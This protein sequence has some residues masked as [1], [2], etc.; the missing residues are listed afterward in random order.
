MVRTIVDEGVRIIVIDSLNGYLHA[1]PNEAAL[2]IQFHEL[3]TFLGRSGVTTLLVVTQPGLIGQDVV[4]PVNA[5]Y[6]VDSVIM[7]RYFE[8]SGR[9][10][11]AISVLK[12]RNGPHQRDIREL[13]LGEAGERLHVGEAL[14]DLEGVMRGTPVLSEP[15]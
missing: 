8:H 7:L 15:E 11:K 9:I 14:T 3:F 2:L 1:M 4:T 13:H 10:R 5:S 12:K 6:L